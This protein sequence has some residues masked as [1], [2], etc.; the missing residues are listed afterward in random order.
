MPLVLVCR[1]RPAHRAGIAQEPIRGE[2]WISAGGMPVDESRAQGGA[3][4]DE[5]NW[6]LEKALK[7][8][9]SDTPGPLG[10]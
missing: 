5:A 2:G 10:D 4:N 8:A 9:E 3:C 7:Q 1:F 6:L